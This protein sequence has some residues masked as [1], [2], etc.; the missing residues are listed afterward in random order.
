MGGFLISISPQ[1]GKYTK[2]IVKKNS[3]TFPVLADKDNA[4]AKK[5]NLDF[6][7]PEKLKEVYKTLGIDLERFNGNASWELPMAARFIID[8]NGIIRHRKVN[9]DHTVRPE[10]GEIIDLMKPLM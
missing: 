4:Y 9:P 1:L 2:Q 10:P 5:L 6:I 3:L 7:L 8:R